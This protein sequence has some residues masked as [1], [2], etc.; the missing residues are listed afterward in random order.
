MWKQAVQKSDSW[1]KGCRMSLIIVLVYYQNSICRPYHR[2]GKPN[3]TWRSHWGK[4]TDV[5]VQGE[6]G[7]KR[8]IK[9]CWK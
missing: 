3:R 2:T 4:E 7:S 9:Q 8:Y 6:S 5:G 1:Q